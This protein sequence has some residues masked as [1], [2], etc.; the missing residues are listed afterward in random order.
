MSVSA[1]WCCDRV[2]F[3]DVILVCLSRQDGAVIGWDLR[4]PGKVL[5]RMERVVDTNQRIYFDSFRYNRG[6]SRRVDMWLPQ[7]VLFKL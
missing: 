2:G 4:S 1:G 5:H 7:A 3:H 6:R